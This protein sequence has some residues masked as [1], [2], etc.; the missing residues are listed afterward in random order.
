MKTL[1]NGT[2]MNSTRSKTELTMLTQIRKSDLGDFLQ[3]AFNISAC[4]RLRRIAIPCYFAVLLAGGTSRAFAQGTNLGRLMDGAILHRLPPSGLTVKVG[5]GIVRMPATNRATGPVIVAKKRQIFPCTIEA[6][7]KADK[8]TS[9]GVPLEGATVTISYV[10]Y[11]SPLLKASSGTLNWSLSWTDGS[12]NLKLPTGSI[13]IENLG[14]NEAR[15]GSF[16][17]KPFAGK[18]TLSLAFTRD[19]AVAVDPEFK[20]PSCTAEYDLDV[21]TRFVAS[22]ESIHIYE[23]LARLKDTDFANVEGSFGGQ[24][25]KS[26]FKFI[27]D[28]SG[29]DHQTLMPVGPFECVPGDH[30]G[31]LWLRLI[32]LNS[33]F[34]G[35]DANKAAQLKNSLDASVAQGFEIDNYKDGTSFFLTK[36]LLFPDCDGPVFIEATE[37]LTTL[38]NQQTLEKGW[39]TQ[40]V[41]SVFGRK[42]ACNAAGSRYDANLAFYRNGT[43]Y[44]VKVTTGNVD[45][46]GTYSH[47]FIRL[48]GERGVG[49]EVHLDDYKENWHRGVTEEF[50]IASQDLGNLQSLTVWHNNKN[51]DRSWF[52]KEITVEDTVNNKSWVFPADAWLA[53]DRGDHEIKRELKPQ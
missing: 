20:N 49:R 1:K 42:G 19:D 33:G 46:A 27:G 14:K 13:R 51:D 23:T 34:E 38:L 32:I 31:A 52:L 11:G 21:A 26:N 16:A 4:R 10:V 25:L 40:T 53:D 6:A 5:G 47:V 3:I 12:P 15:A 29:G 41:Q 22:L 35:S 9:T 43:I 44:R 18:F 30:L 39:Y 48:K 17:L 24:G 37:Y 8:L 45:D 50:L 36:E 7:V 28:L 2:A